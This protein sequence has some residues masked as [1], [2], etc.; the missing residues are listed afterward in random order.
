M[1]KM[2]ASIGLM[3][4][5]LSCTLY[6]LWPLHK[7]IHLRE[8]VIVFIIF[9]DPYKHYSSAFISVHCQIFFF[10]FLCYYQFISKKYKLWLLS[11]RE[12]R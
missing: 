6:I 1:Y 2:F 7:D 9:L 5:P 4:P 11:F 3:L 8:T 12:T 10:S